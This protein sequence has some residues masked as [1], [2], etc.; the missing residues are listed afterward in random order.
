[1]K[2]FIEPSDFAIIAVA[3]FGLLN[4]A[5]HADNLR[6]PRSLQGQGQGRPLAE[7]TVN[8]NAYLQIPSEDPIAGG[9]EEVGC[10]DGTGTFLPLDLDD[11]QAASVRDLAQNGELNYGLSKIGIDGARVGDDGVVRMPPGQAISV[12]AKN[13][14]GGNDKALFHRNRE[15]QQ[16]TGDKHFI[17]FRVTDSAGAVYPDSPAVMSNKLFGTGGDTINLK[18]QMTACSVGKYT[19]VPGGRTNYDIAGLESAP[20]VV[21]IQLDITLDSTRNTV[22]N[23]A[24]S[25]AKQVMGNFFG[26]STSTSLTTYADHTL[27]S[28]KECRQECGWA[29]YAGVG[30]Y[31]QFYQSAYYKYAG[32]Q[33]H[34]HGHNMQLAHSGGLDGQTY[35]DHTCSMGNP[36]YGDQAGQMCFN[37][38]KNWQMQFNPHPTT[39]KSGWYD[40]A[41]F[42]EVDTSLGA[43]TFQMMGIGEYNLQSAP[44]KAVAL[45]VLTG[46]STPQYVAFNSAKGANAQN[47]EADNLVTIM[48]YTGTSYGVSSLK[49]YVAAGNEFTTTQGRVVRAQCINTSVTPSL[50]C[51]CVRASGQTCPTDCACTDAPTPPPTPAPTAPPTTS[52]PTPPP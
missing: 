40:S 22:R 11:S 32:V 24:L 49:G 1:M 29:A 17:L 6:R 20:G 50:A 14:G 18:T 28:L 48:E 8:L 13:G 5:V 10:D 19:I 36:L 25:K 43:R 45:K 21:D 44:R 39:V 34:E 23:A 33:L 2:F 15:L 42:I 7:C 35:T 51:V 46:T 47:D 41:D 52:A 37:P 31:Y 38:A 9:D 16:G 27:F 30:S 26:L 12:V 4:S 3:G